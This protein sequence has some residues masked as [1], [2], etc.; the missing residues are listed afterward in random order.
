MYSFSF[1]QISKI[2]FYMNGNFSKKIN[3]YDHRFPSK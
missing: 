1:F 2:N 3:E